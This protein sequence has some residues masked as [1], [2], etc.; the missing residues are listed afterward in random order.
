MT[1]STAPKLVLIDGHSLLYRAFFALPPLTNAKGE[2]TNAA[3][4][5][6]A[7]LFKIL[8]EEQPDM[9]A[10]AF[11]LPTPTFRHRRYPDYKATRQQ[12]PDELGPQIEMARRNPG[13]DAHPHLHRR[14][15]RGR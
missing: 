8:D 12:M 14:G 2:V 15:L 5:F 7:M 13:G 3:Y 4:G 1:E 11:D 10:V 9:I 6:T